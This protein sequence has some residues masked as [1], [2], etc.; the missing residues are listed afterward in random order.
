ML[1]SDI[2]VAEQ[3]PEIQLK[4]KHNSGYICTYLLLITAMLLST[5]K[6]IISK[7]KFAKTIQ[8]EVNG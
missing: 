5:G 8:G 1:L 7:Y 4:L 2:S 6:I 3:L